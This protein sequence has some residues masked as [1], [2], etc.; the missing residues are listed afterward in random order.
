MQITVDIPESLLAI[1]TVDATHR[2]Q[3][4]IYDAAIGAYCRD[5]ITRFELQQIL[6]I[7]TRYELDGVLKHL[8][9]EHGAYS[10]QDLLD[11][12]AVFSSI[13]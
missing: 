8:G 5:A 6:G 7:E 9:V 1:A 3:Q 13:E 10:G 2:S 4:L 12:L 11:D